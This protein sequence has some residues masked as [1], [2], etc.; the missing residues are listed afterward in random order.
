MTH[1]AG[2][3]I[4]IIFPSEYPYGREVGQ[5]WNFIKIIWFLHHF[6]EWA[7]FLDLAQQFR[8]YLDFIAPKN[9]VFRQ[10]LRGNLHIW[11]GTKKK[12]FEGFFAIFWD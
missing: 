9:G 6:S 3:F 10:D 8:R 2:I 4:I 12:I 7:H 11:N 5:N 1:F